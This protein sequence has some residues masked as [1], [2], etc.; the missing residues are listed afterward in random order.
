VLAIHTG[1]HWQKAEHV[2]NRWT[3]VP[4][5]ESTHPEQK[6]LLLSD[7]IE[8]SE[9]PW[10][11]LNKVASSPAIDKI[12]LPAQHSRL[13]DCFRLLCTIHK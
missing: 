9:A 2:Q 4:E 6:Q 1:F 7:P 10:G 13:P 8:R 11:K 12:S 3:H 5:P